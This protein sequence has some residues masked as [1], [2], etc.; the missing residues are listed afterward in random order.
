M[1]TAIPRGFAVKLYAE[2][3]NYDIVGNNRP[4]SSSGDPFKFPDMV[5]ARAPSPVEPEGP[6]PSGRGVRRIACVRRNR[7][8]TGRRDG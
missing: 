2:E 8:P 7:L 6:G 3:G 4:A 1:P 5:Q